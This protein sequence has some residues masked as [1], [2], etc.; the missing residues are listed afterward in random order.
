[1]K[2]PWKKGWNAANQDFLSIWK[3]FLLC[4]GQIL[5]LTTFDLSSVNAFNLDQAEILS[6]GKEFMS[7]M[8]NVFHWFSKTFRAEL[9]FQLTTSCVLATYSSTE[10]V[11]LELTVKVHSAKFHWNDPLTFPPSC[12]TMEYVCGECWPRSDCTYV[13]SYLPLLSRFFHN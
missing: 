13:Q 5:P 2:T 12:A 8:I 11:V 9:R 7:L 4:R 10:K 1:M 3:Y 6:F